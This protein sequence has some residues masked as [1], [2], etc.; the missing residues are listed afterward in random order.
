M[1]I[2]RFSVEP[3]DL[4]GWIVKREDPMEVYRFQDKASA[5]IFAEALAQ[6]YRPSTVTVRLKDGGIEK[7]STYPLPS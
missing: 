2:V 1:R 5:A 4:D 7:E 6:R 3:D